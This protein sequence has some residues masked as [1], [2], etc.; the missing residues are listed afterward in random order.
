MYFLIL[1]ATATFK[2]SYVNLSFNHDL[3]CFLP[4]VIDYLLLDRE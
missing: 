4:C 3:N 1:L 2:K